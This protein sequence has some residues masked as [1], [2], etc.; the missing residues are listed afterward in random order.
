MIKRMYILVHI[1]FYALMALCF[2]TMSILFLL[3]KDI[4]FVK[5]SKYLAIAVLCGG[6]I[7][8]V[9]LVIKHG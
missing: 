1:I 3:T 6:I 2:A 8:I 9:Y 5:I 4:V 7:H